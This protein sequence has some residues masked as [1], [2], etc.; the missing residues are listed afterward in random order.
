MS[1]NKLVKPVRAKQTEEF[2]L[3]VQDNWFG[4]L[5]LNIRDSL[6]HDSRPVIP[7]GLRHYA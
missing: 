5:E 3:S 4:L 2:Y 6:V 1:F 7:A